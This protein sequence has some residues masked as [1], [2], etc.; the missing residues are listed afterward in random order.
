MCPPNNQKK[1]YSEEE[2]DLLTLDF[3]SII[4]G[5]FDDY[6]LTDCTPVCGI[7][8]N[9]NENVLPPIETEYNIC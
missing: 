2:N 6:S 7:P 3:A 9:S 8:Y 5:P 1:G 4:D